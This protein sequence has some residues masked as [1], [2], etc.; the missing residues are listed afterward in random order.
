[1][2]KI[3]Y[4]YLQCSFLCLPLK[5]VQFL[6]ANELIVVGAKFSMIHKNII[7]IFSVPEIALGN[8]FVAAFFSVVA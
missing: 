6:K 8:G 3:A 7:I 1:M 4:V 2:D 5:R